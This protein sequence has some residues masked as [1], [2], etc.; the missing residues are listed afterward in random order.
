[1][2]KFR[3]NVIPVSYKYDVNK[4]NNSVT[5]KLKYKIS[6]F[7]ISDNAAINY[8]F[9]TFIYSMASTL[10]MFPSDEV[11]TVKAT[12]KL[13]KDDIRQG[14]MFDEEF[15][16]KLAKTKAQ[17]K[18]YNNASDIYNAVLDEFNVLTD[19]LCNYDSN[20][21]AVVDSDYKHIEEL[22]DKKYGA[23]NF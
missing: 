11:F 13:S 14:Y 5:C 16:K 19:A 9:M 10:H 22:I 23:D 1:M 4:D 15:G 12:A 6:N 18:A 17:I 7:N 20:C 3:T 8:K 21:L 2:S